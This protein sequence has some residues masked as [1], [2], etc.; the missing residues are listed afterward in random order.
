VKIILYQYPGGEG[1]GSVS[2]PCLRVDMALRWLGVEFERRD[3]RRGSAVR[4][5]SATGR[6]PVLEID[7]E[8]FVES[9]R[10]LDELDRR[11]DPP[12]KVDSPNDATHLRLWEYAVTDSFYW[13]GFYQRWVDPA[14]NERFLEHLLR[15]AGPVRGFLMRK[16]LVPGR[17]KRALLHGVGARPK[18]DVDREIERALDMLSVDLG[19]GPFLL[20]RDRPS[21]AD[22]TVCA[23]WVQAGFGGTMPGV[24]EELRGREAILPYLK[25][26]CETV[27]G[28]QPRWLG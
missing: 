26:V 19:P 21:R 24:V 2:P 11:F 20:G 6:M 9:T 18:A 8:R 28:E 3:L 16:L 7:G 22:L 15:G 5:V 4:E 25:R 27:G 1:I 23:L 17:R 14:G 12:W 10:I 13:L